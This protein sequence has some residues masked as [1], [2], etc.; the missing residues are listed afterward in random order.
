ML[1]T[2]PATETRIFARMPLDRG[3]IVEVVRLAHSSDRCRV[4]EILRELPSRCEMD[5]QSHAAEPE[6]VVARLGR[7]RLRCDTGHVRQDFAAIQA[8][9]CE[10]EVLFV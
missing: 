1:P 8:H 6:R 10:P 9:A 2:Y 3:A 4:N 5:I 7:R